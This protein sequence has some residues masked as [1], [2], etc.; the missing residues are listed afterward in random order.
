MNELVTV[1][2]NQLVTD[3]RQVAE[4]F[5]KQHQHVIRDIENLVNKAEEKDA[6]K[7]GRMFF[8]TTMPDAYGRHHILELL[9]DDQEAGH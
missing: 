8:E 4:H 7:I 5:E 6:S 1:Y 2:K 3:S 9:K